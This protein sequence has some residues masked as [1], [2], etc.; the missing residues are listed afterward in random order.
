MTAG[1]CYGH[2][3]Y[4][5]GLRRKDGSAWCARCQQQLEAPDPRRAWGR[6]G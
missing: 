2:Q 5:A 3:A 4:L 6:R 1:D